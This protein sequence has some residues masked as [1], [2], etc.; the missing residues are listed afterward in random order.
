MTG[1]TTDRATVLSLMA[2]YGELDG[3]IAYRYATAF[4]QVN[5]TLTAGQRAQLMALRTEMLGAMLYPSG[6]YLDSQPIA[7]PEIPGTDF[8]LVV[9]PL[10]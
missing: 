6:A 4:A 10:P 5:Q 8:L 1:G 7:M 9:P 2:R 3:E